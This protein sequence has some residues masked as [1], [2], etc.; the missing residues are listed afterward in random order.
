MRS[1][2]KKQLKKKARKLSNLL[3]SAHRMRKKILNLESLISDLQKNN[4]ISESMGNLLKMLPPGTSEMLKRVSRGQ[5]KEKYPAALQTFALTLNFYSR[6]AYSYIRRNFNTSLPHPRTL[7]RWYSVIDGNPGFSKEEAVA[8]RIESQELM[9]KGKKLL[10]AMSFDEIAV[11]KHI[12][13]RQNKFVG[14]V[15]YGGEL[16]DDNLPVANEALTFMVTAVN[17]S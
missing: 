12:E 10:C 17:S 3:R 6:K 8:L 15:D 13:F 11:R 4:L 1:V 7:R 9:N 5:T 2:A 16:D 14:Y